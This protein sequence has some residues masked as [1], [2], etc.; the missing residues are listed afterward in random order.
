MGKRMSGYREIAPL[1]L[2]LSIYILT[3]SGIILDI[4]KEI[5]DYDC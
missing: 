2:L 5:Y 1:N 4:H 3:K